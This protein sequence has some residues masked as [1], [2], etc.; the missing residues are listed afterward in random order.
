LSPLR[1]ALAFTLIEDSLVSRSSLV[2]IAN[3][4][5]LSPSYFAQA[6]K[7]STGLSPYQWLARRR[8]DKATEL[9]VGSKMPLS[10]VATRCGF[11]DQAHFSKAFRKA[12]GVPP[13]VWKRDSHTQKLMP[14]SR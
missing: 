1:L 2:Q 6:F 11:V 13:S 9:L 10:E 7:V 5:G 4:C 12:K 3:D 8:I 14:E